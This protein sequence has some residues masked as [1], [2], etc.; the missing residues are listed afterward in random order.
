M[1]RKRL[2]EIFSAGCSVCQETVRM[3]EDMACPSCEIVVLDMH[4]D[5]VAARAAQLGITTVPS[6]VVDGKLADCCSGRGPNEPALRAAGVG[7]P[8]R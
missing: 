6:V 2:I 7:Q 1:A 4:D 8:I 5:A 3:V